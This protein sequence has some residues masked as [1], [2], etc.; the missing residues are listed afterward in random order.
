MAQSRS[1]N[2]MAEALQG[3]LGDISQIKVMPD[4]DLEWLV[5]L[6]TMILAKLREPIDQL[7]GQ[8]P[9]PGDNPMAFGGSDNMQ[10]QPPMPP[11][12]PMPGGGLPLNM[13]PQPGTARST[14]A[15]RVT[16][17]A[18]NPDE[19]RRMVGAGS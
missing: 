14:G 16:P 5:N 9:P 8:L 2:T 11:P 3:L 12:A 18:P 6:E 4:A 1:T 10:G 19:V 7:A 17:G 13:L 15:R